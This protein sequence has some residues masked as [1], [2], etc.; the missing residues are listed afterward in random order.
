MA[1]KIHFKV[2]EKAGEFVAGIRN[3]GAGKTLPLT[4][5]QAEY[6][7]ILG[8]LERPVRPADNKAKPKAGPETAA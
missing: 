5:E 4:E 6:A 3:P 8:E 2:T 1:D 7:L